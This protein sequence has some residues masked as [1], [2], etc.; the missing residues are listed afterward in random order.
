MPA[1]EY[2]AAAQHGALALEQ[3]TVSLPLLLPLDASELEITEAIVAMA[4]EA[5]RIRGRLAI[6]R[7]STGPF[8]GYVE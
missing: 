1:L 8:A 6:A 3:G 5:A 7:G 2:N 4:Y